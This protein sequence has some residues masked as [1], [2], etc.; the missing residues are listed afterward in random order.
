M[1]RKQKYGYEFIE[2]KH[3]GMR[4][5]NGRGSQVGGSN[6]VDFEFHLEV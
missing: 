4:T 6:Q 3:G 5:S 1:F 2:E